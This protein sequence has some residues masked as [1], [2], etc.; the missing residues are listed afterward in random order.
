MISS[1][2]L[3]KKIKLIINSQPRSASNFLIN[4]MVSNTKIK[5]FEIYHTHDAELLNNKKY[6]Q[7]CLI[8]DPL[9][10]IISLCAMFRFFDRIPL[11]A[12]LELETLP[13]FQKYKIERSNIKIQIKSLTDFFDNLKNNL[14]HVLVFDFND[15]I[16][17]TENVI[18]KISNKYDIKIKNIINT[19]VNVYDSLNGNFLKSSKDVK[20]YEIIKNN[21]NKYE[22]EIKELQNSYRHCLEKI[23][24]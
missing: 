5:D 21:I 17:N 15:V 20:H 22:K 8:R 14:N 19:N 16:N 23:N 18:E 6:N 12:D 9:D 24:G 3:N 4:Q 10:S 11:S 2:P 1:V 7:V 13:G